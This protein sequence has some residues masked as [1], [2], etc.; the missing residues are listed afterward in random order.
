[1]AIRTQ[2]ISI[3]ISPDQERI[4]TRPI[5]QVQPQ[6]RS[7]RGLVAAV[8]RTWKATEGLLTASTMAWHEMYR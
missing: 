6:T 2:A 1:M 7:R 8:R 4:D 3:P 5:E